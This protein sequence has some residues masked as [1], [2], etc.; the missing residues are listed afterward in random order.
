MAPKRF[1]S[2]K[3]KPDLA[4]STSAKFLVIVESPSKCNK[5]EQYLGPDYQCIASKGHIRELTGLKNIDVKNDFHPTFTLIAEKADHVKQ[6]SKVIQQYKHGAIY[7]A[8]DDDREG[9]GIAWH[10]CQVFNLPVETTKRILF[11]EITK[12]A[13]QDA[14]KSP[15]LIN[16]NVVYAQQTRQ[17]LDVIVGFKTSPLLWKHIHSSKSKALSAGRCQTPAL[18]LVYDNEME[19]KTAGL[20]MRY[21]TVGHFFSPAIDFV[22]DREFEMAADIEIF[23][24][25]SRD[26]KHSLAIGPAKPTKKA[27]PKPFNTSRL[28]QVASSV[29]H[30]S[31]KQTMQLC[32]SLYQNGFIT[33]MRTENTKYAG[34]FLETMRKFILD[35]YVENGS[36]YLGNLDAL[37]NNDKTNPHEAI[38]VTNIQLR[39]LSETADAKEAAMYSLIWRTTLESCMAVAEYNTT[40]VSISGPEMTVSNTK[41]STS[42]KHVLEIPVFL[43]WKQVAQD[44]KTSIVCHNTKENMD[45]DDLQDDQDASKR[46]FFF[47]SLSKATCANVPFSYIES[48]VVVRNKHSYYTEASLIQRL[49]EL[50]IGRPST[51]AMLVDTI[52]DRGY[53]KRMDLEGIVQ[54]CVEYKLVDKG[55]NKTAKDAIVEK[56]TVKKPFGK[57]KNKL[58]IQPT[59][60]LCI[61]FL[62][63]HFTELFS[64][65]YTKKMEDE[66]DV[67]MSC[68]SD[69]VETGSNS[70]KTLLIDLC[71]RCYVDLTKLIKSMHIEKVEY[72]IDDDHTLC[73]QQYG[74]TIKSVDEDGNKS[75][76]KVKG[77]MKIDLEKMKHGE[78]TVEDLVE[79][80][81]PEILGEYRGHPLH[82]KT[83]RYGPYLQ[84]SDKKQ[85]V[86]AM[87]ID[88]KEITFE[89]AVAFLDKVLGESA[90]APPQNKNVLSALTTDLSIRSG[91]FGPYIFYQTV[92]MKTPTFFPM[93]KCPHDYKTCKVDVLVKWIQETHLQ[94]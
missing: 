38:R 45:A 7:L 5:I 39:R 58:L 36:K 63:Q 4:V 17:I 77:D 34:P 14:V 62:V 37:E 42:Y 2:K 82:L 9:E 55:I 89:L 86:K 76:K 33:Y 47:K 74:P 6:M 19:K 78:Y 67:M 28:L 87:D 12:A 27:P 60:I 3:A 54:D 79:V 20:E 23:L 8:T 73:F 85:S 90:R 11:H 61:E 70:S 56:H 53:V 48:T 49:E 68:N 69:V 75:Y 59:G 91:K 43:G 26:H 13:V 83:G 92:D 18:R 24:D 84:W 52:Q 65:D 32:Q 64:Y 31:P 22:L 41:A 80:S 71:R 35:E 72:A 88:V 93:K 81:V 21:K 46:L 51:F 66:L 16:M 94:R 29:L 44:R 10:I 50:G 40:T 30:T 1:Y 25:K 57:E 15:G